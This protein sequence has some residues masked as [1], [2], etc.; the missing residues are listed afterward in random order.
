LREKKREFQRTM[1]SLPGFRRGSSK[2]LG[3]SGK[4]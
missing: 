2:I 3:K 4:I 1:L